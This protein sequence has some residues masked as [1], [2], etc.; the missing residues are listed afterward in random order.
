MASLFFQYLWASPNTIV[1][2]F[3]ALIARLTGGGW[4][5][6][7]GVLEA[8]GGA[9]AWCLQRMPF[10][11]GGF[12]AIT[13]GHVVLGAHIYALE[14]TRIHERVHVQQYGHWGVFFLPAYVISSLVA[15]VRG[16]DPYR[17][18][19]FERT[20]YRVEAETKL[21]QRKDSEQA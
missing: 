18:N 10:N 8:W 13:F 21:A 11:K 19:L 5:M 3:L 6:H 17:D 1:G 12:A 9:P 15:M 16:Q 7:S 20:A 4:Q 2:G 14:Y